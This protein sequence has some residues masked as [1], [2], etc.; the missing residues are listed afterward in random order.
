MRKSNRSMPSRRPGKPAG[1][2]RFNWTASLLVLSFAGAAYSQ[3]RLQVVDRDETLDRAR[4]S[5]RFIV[6]RT[7][8]AKRGAIFSAD[9]KALA[10]DAD[11]YSL[12]V[13]FERV[14]QSDAFFVDL[15]AATGIPAAEFAQL[16]A[17][18]A[19]TKTWRTPMTPAQMKAVQEVKTRWRADGVS[20]PRSGLRNYPL[21]EAASCIVGIAS[22]SMKLGLERSQEERLGGTNGKTIGQVDRGGSFLP[23]RLE[24]GTVPKRDGTNLTLTLDSELQTLATIEIRKAVETNK[25]ERGVAIVMDPKT[26]DLL[27]MANWPSFDPNG[28]NPKQ[29]GPV[30][31]FN[32]NT[33]SQL[34]PGSTFKILTLAKALDMNKITPGWGMYCGGQLQVGKRYVRCDDHHG[35]RA[36]GA[37]DIEKSIAKSCNVAAAR[38][39]LQVGYEDMVGF[40]RDLGVLEKANLG[41]PGERAGLFNF[42]EYAKALQMANVGFGQSLNVTPVRLASAFSMLA[43]GGIRMEPRLIKKIGEREEPPIT[44][45]RV[46]SEETAKEVLEAMESVIESDAGTGHSLRIPGYR[47]GGKTGTAQRIGSGRQGYVSN[48]IGFVPAQQPRAVILVMVDNPRA[49]KYYGSAVAGPVFKSLARAAIRRF[50]IVPTEPVVAATPRTEAR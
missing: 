28:Q 36:H 43:N 42:N 16:A 18:G 32:P 26:G 22:P 29:R 10:Q 33:M 27:A 44:A 47:L 21:G 14:P 35:S 45:G 7:E 40:L 6:E 37:I 9:G 19:G 11:T 8:I 34:E 38:W 17:H 5:Q 4:A 20:M 46:V 1:S 23:M 12:V 41:M 49:G 30:S 39:A 24:D 50:A 13:Q 25:A 48:F 15:S 31:D 3:V 2:D